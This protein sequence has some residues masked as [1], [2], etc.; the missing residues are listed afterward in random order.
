MSG[1]QDGWLDTLGSHVTSDGKQ[2]AL[3]YSDICFDWLFHRY[4]ALYLSSTICF[5]SALFTLITAIVY[6]LCRPSESSNVSSMNALL[7]AC[8]LKIRKEI[9]ELRPESEKKA[10]DPATPFPTWGE[11]FSLFLALLMLESNQLL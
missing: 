3:P 11:G 6:Y 9:R 5:Y 8:T 7:R 10:V 4:Q 1:N 2:C